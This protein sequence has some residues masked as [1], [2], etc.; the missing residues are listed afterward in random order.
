MAL[1]NPS[2]QEMREELSVGEEFVESLQQART[3]LYQLS[4]RAS[5]D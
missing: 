4:H 3:A 1:I 5:V 2:I